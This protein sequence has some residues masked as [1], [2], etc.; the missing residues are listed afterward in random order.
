MI[1]GVNHFSITVKD[2]DKVVAFFRDRLGL[3]HIWPTYEYKGQMI[4]N[5]TGLSGAHL[6]IAKIEVGEVILEF[7]QYLAPPGRELKGNTNDVGCPHIGFVVDD[8]EE[9][10][11]TLTEQ[12]VRFKSP[13]QWNRNEGHPMYG[14]GGSLFMGPRGYHPGVDA[15]AEIASPADITR[16]TPD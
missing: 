11:K 7:I 10:Y 4:D 2:L 16:A 15:G 3:T 6:R 1:L 8:I 13:P 14:W 12:G 9:M 5:V